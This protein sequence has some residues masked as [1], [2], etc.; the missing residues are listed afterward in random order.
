MAIAQVLHS[1][2]GPATI[3]RMVAGLDQ[4]WAI[5]F[6]PDGSFLVTQR[7]GVLSY[8]QDGSVQRVRGVPDVVADGQGGLLDVM[9]PRDF[10]T[11]R[12]V[13]LSYSKALTGGS[14]T[15]LAVGILSRNARKLNDVR[16]LFEMN[17]GAQGGRHFGSRITE[18]L[19]GTIFLTLGDRGNRPAAQDLALHNG[20][21]VRIN[22]DGSVPHD[23]PFVDQPG[24]RPEIFSFGH[25]NP[26]GMALDTRGRLWTAEHGAKGGDEVNLI[27]KGAN[28]GWPIISYGTHYSGEK[29]GEG[30]ARADMKQPTHY[31]DPSIAPSGLMIYSGKLWPRW[32]GNLF[33]GSLKFDYIARLAGD[34]VNEVEQ[35]KGPETE[36]VR[37]IVEAPDGSI[38]FISVGN[39]AI[40]R[41]APM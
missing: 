36:R 39:G 7:D 21:V 13:F 23:N 20:S 3:T 6:L 10:D 25:R 41:L 22:R 29:I 30:T 18:A 15:A 31:W 8:V 33:V 40:Y 16:V 1:S 27:E 38:W 28:Y 34:D 12:E 14:G 24:T 17:Q 19:D 37:D 11:S 5:G 9:I 4:P 26:Q 32:R 2:A 35:L